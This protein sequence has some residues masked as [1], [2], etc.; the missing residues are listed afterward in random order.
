MLLLVAFISQILWG[1]N[2][3]RKLILSV[4]S[5]RD[6]AWMNEEVLSSRFDFNIMFFPLNLLAMFVAAPSLV[7][8]HHYSDL[9]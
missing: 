3:K 6:S 7:D 4:A 5:S 9:V 1:L 2:G 8:V